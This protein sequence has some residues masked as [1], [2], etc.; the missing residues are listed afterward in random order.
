MCNRQLN[1]NL[2]REQLNDIVRY[3]DKTFYKF[4]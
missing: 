1:T 2:S 4:P 3:L